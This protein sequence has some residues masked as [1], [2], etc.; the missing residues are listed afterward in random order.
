MKK[1]IFFVALATFLMCSCQTRAKETRDESTSRISGLVSEFSLRPNFEV[2]R[3]GRLGMGL[4]RTVLRSSMEDDDMQ[5]LD[6]IRDV[7][8]IIIANYEDCDEVVRNEF[9]TRLSKYLDKDCLLLEAKDSGEK[10][11]IY[12]ETSDRG[13]RITNLII[14]APESG[15]LICIYGTIPVESLSKIVNQ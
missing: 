3:L 15:A 13:D 2:I 7:R 4:V 9:T 6:I 14:N 12:G 10:V 11:Q 5:V 1:C 8:K